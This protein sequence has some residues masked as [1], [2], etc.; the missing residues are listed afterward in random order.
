MVESS[1]KRKGSYTSASATIIWCLGAT[2]A[3]PTSIPPSFSSSTLFL[4]D[5][6]RLWYSSL[7]SSR[8]ILDPKYLDLKFFTVKH[9]IVINCFKT[10]G[11]FPL[12]LLL[13]TL[14]WFPRINI[15]VDWLNVKRLHCRHSKIFKWLNQTKH[16]L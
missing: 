7:F 2:G 3:P 11:W 10:M 13:K 6:Q 15:S 9:L 1:K 4:S 16:T 14:G 12:C 5:E 8:Q